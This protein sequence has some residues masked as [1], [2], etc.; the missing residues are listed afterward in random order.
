MLQSYVERRLT[1]HRSSVAEHPR[2][3]RSANELAAF[4]DELFAASFVMVVF[5]NQE[6][7]QSA[8]D[9]RHD[10]NLAGALATYAS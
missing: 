8:R 9:V 6:S 1:L 10:T 3:S 7:G 2:S 4:A 5:C